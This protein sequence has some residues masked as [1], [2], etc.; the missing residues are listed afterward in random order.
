M[1]Y[2]GAHVSDYKTE[3]ANGVDKTVEYIPIKPS[4]AM[5]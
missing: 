3:S 4:V 5:E 2:V 1:W